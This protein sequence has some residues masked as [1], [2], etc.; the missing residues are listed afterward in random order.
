MTEDSYRLD[1]SL[2]TFLAGFT[3]DLSNPLTTLLGYSQLLQ[4]STSLEKSQQYAETILAQ[5]K[6]CQRRIQGL[7]CYLSLRPPQMKPLALEQLLRVSLD[8]NK[9][10]CEAQRIALNEDISDRTTL[11]KGD[12]SLIQ[13]SL[14]MLLEN[15][16]VALATGVESPTIS[17]RLTQDDDWAWIVVQDNG[18]G[19]SV[20]RLETLFSPE[21]TTRGS[22]NGLGLGLPTTRSIVESH[23]GSVACTV[24]ATSGLC[25][26]MQFPLLKDK[27]GSV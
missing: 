19:P 26:R 21:Y 12:G 27:D 15:A 10:Y 18:A 9:A 20:E 3:H 23:G 4:R 1:D 13:S 25:V 2:R 16:V 17:V 14:D 7:Q 6:R 24:G 5:A 11:I 8:S 22:G